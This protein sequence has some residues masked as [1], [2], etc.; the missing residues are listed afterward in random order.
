MLI[1]KFD[2]LFFSAP[3]SRSFFENANI[4]YM[5]TKLKKELQDVVYTLGDE[6]FSLEEKVLNFLEYHKVDS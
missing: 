1:I 2:L 6:N 5:Y 4:D 3:Y